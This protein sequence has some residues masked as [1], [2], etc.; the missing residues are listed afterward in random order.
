M[1]CFLASLGAYSG[2]FI[3]QKY[4]VKNQL[5]DSCFSIVRRNHVAHYRRIN[6]V[7]SRRNGPIVQTLSWRI[8]PANNHNGDGDTSH[9]CYP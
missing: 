3:N 6:F 9:R 7:L 4:I 1:N 5:T 2:T 8:K